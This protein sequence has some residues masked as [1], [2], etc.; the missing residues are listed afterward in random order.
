M[1]GG[2]LS[3]RG[4]SEIARLAHSKACRR[5]IARSSWLS[6][7]DSWG[8][9]PPEAPDPGGRA[10]SAKRVNGGKGKGDT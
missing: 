8:R 7:Q 3:S 1:D 4:R 9:A 6:S 5:V 2:A 10:S